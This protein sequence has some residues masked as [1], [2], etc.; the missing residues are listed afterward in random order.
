MSVARQPELH[1]RDR[2]DV[3]GPERRLPL[4]LVLDSRS[5]E[6]PRDEKG[7][8]GRR[9][10]AVGGGGQRPR[11][12]RASEE[13]SPNSDTQ[14]AADEDGVNVAFHRAA[15]RRFD[16]VIGADGLHSPCAP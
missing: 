4:S 15:P 7:W 3:S 8:P 11:T 14:E 16:L 13:P 12:T 5:W 2:A 1:D 10:N 6:C 9:A